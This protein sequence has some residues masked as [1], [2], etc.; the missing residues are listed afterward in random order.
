MQDTTKSDLK[1]TGWQSME[2]AHLAQNRDQRRDLLNVI[3]RLGV[4]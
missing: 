2:W 1:V 3:V 4:P